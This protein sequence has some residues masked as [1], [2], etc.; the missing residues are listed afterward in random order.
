M[1]SETQAEQP[2]A[3]QVGLSPED[4]I[5]AVMGVTGSGKSSFISLLLE[6]DIGVG[7][8]LTSCTTAVEMHILERENGRKIFLIDTPGF[9]D[10]NRPDIEVLKD[11][12]FFLSQTYRQAIQLTGIVYLHKIT[13][14]RMS[15]S[16]VRNLSMFKQ[17]CGESVYPHVVL[18]TTMWSYLDKSPVLHEEGERHMKELIA[19]P[20]WWGF[21][22][23][24]GSKVVRHTGERESALRIIDSL[25]ESRDRNMT[26]NIQ[27]ELVVEELSLE[28]TGAGREAEK[29]IQDAKVKWEEQVKTLQDDYETAL[30]DRDQQVAAMLKAQRDEL[31][32]KIEAATHAQ[33]ALKINLERLLEE[34]SAD[35]KSLHEQLVREQR[36]N[37]ALIA[38]YEQQQAQLQKE[39]KQEADSYLEQKAQFEKQLKQI[40][41]RSQQADRQ[42]E[43][44]YAVKLE[45]DRRRHEQWKNELEERFQ[46]KD[47]DLQKKQ[48]ELSTKIQTSKKKKNKRELITPVL[49]VLSSVG[50]I[51]AGVLT[52]QP[53][54]VA[55]G[56]S[57]LS[58]GGNEAAGNEAGGNEDTANEVP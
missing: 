29:E 22:H 5:I 50:L 33:Q 51:V 52:F 58:S 57:G 18:A 31:Q 10:T 48:A 47:A 41:E 40:E 1:A 11:V 16:S 3:V 21:M 38:R 56:V 7:H 19:R 24:R 17:L 6:E 23:D 46:Q 9:D 49:G 36:S 20:D 4:A 28:K 13:D 53:D 15:G 43:Q 54:M 44:D 34:K 32:G 25:I 39:R 35:Y 37:E 55:T 26:L 14:N 2:P 12:A 27:R 8:G 45:A 30:K 42:K